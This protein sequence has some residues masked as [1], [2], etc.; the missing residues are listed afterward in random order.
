MVHAL[1]LPIC[2]V[3]IYYQK[4]GVQVQLHTYLPTYGYYYNVCQIGCFTTQQCL[5]P[6]HRNDLSVRV[7][8][9]L[10]DFKHKYNFYIHTVIL[11]LY[12]SGRVV[13]RES[14]GPGFVSCFGQIVFINEAQWTLKTLG[15]ILGI[16]FIHLE[17]FPELNSQVKLP[18]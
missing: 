2:N 9:Q 17:V 10:K 18:L 13:S 11:T 8:L 4:C 1:L 5:Y 12:L 15:I 3:V 7:G 6:C 16:F 14:R